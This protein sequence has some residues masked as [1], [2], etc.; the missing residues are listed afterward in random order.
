MVWCAAGNT[1]EVL[2]MSAP[3]QIYKNGEKADMFVATV[4][5]KRM[6]RKITRL[7]KKEGRSMSGL[8]RIAIEQYIERQQKMEE[9]YE[10]YSKE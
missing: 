1:N 10:K 6:K 2:K 4:V 8:V 3:L 9:L 7:A 5:S